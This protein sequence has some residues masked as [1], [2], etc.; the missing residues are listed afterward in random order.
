MNDSISLSRRMLLAGAAGLLGTGIGSTTA[1]AAESKQGGATVSVPTNGRTYARAPLRSDFVTV[2]A[3]QSRV[4]AVD[5]KNP[6]KGI[7]AN[8]DHMLEL[9]DKAQF[10]GGRK[11]LLCFHEFP[12]QG[13]NP[14]NREEIMRLAIEI[15]GPETEELAAKAKQYNC[16]IKFGAYAVDQDWPGHILSITTIIGPDGKLVARDWKARNIKGVFPG[17]ELMGTTVYN[18]LDR[19]IEMYGADAV[20][21][22]HH[23]DIGNLCTSSVQLEPELFRVMAMKGAEIFLRTASG[24]FTAADIQ[25]CSAYNKVYSVIVN[26]AVSP[27]NPGFMDDASGASGGT[28]IY[29]P[30]GERVAV[31]DSKFEQ[32]VISRIPMAKFRATHQIP[33]VHMALYEPVFQAYQ[34]RFGPGLFTD[35]QPTGLQDAKKY[36]DR[37]DRWR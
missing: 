30:R 1:A 2:S 24:G 23:T 4:R 36:L 16:Y 3:V 28:A 13:W 9:I 34:P 29:D 18:A 7:R 5:G 27:D 17:F 35:Y 26:N 8:L 22:V 6:A 20:I 14:W 19:F 25:M 33:D 12:L 31:A 10:F 32:Q 21:P 37:Q 11:D 15:P